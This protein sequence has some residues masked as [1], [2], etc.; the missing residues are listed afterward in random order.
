MNLSLE[1]VSAR[2]GIP[3]E[4][5]RKQ[6]LQ[7]QTL[8]REQPRSQNNPAPVAQPRP[9][10]NYSPQGGPLRLQKQMQDSGL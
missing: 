9:K 7:I 8:R 4:Q 10:Y 1:D 6:Q 5:L 3:V 2:T